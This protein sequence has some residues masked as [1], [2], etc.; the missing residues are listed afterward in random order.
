MD[1]PGLDFDLL[2]ASIRAD[3]KDLSLF[4]EVLATKLGGAIPG[5]IRLEHEGGL[6]SKKKVKRLQV[7]L[8]DHQYAL[9]RAGQGL[10]A[11]HSH[12]V[13]GITLRTE[14]LGV[15]EW[16]QLLSRQLAEHAQS[17]AQAR[18]ALDTLLQQ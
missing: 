9:S 11:T 13:R 7:Q 17:S 8:A 12:T 6:F 5:A 15:D 2:A 10:E 14:T 4:L 18:S 16:I 3:S 1:D